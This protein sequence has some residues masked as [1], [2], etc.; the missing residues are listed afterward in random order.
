MDRCIR[1]S[2][3]FAI[4]LLHNLDELHFNCISTWKFGFNTIGHAAVKKLNQSTGVY[5]FYRSWLV[6]GVHNKF[7]YLITINVFTGTE[8]THPCS[9]HMLQL[10]WYV[11]ILIKHGKKQTTR[12]HREL[13][14]WIH[15]RKRLS[16]ST[17]VT[18]YI[19]I[20]DAIPL[21]I[22]LIQKNLGRCLMY[23]G[24]IVQTLPTLFKCECDVVHNYSIASPV[25]VS[26][27]TPA[28]VYFLKIS[29]EWV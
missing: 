5:L 3:Q 24:S 1:E 10:W 18:W 6:V 13:E 4:W 21:C 23:L 7:W 8:I 17:S 28:L 22:V 15:R 9:L 25:V 14:S 19:Q 27:G 2:S 16:P 12:V 29:G 11:K 20:Q 26:K